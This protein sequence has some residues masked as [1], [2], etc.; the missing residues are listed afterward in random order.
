MHSNDQ[1]VTL[2]EL[3]AHRNWLRRACAA[4]D[5]LGERVVDPDLFYRPGPASEA[6][7]KEVCTGCLIRETCLAYALG[8]HGAQEDGVWGGLTAAE[9]RVRRRHERKRRARLA[10]YGGHRPEPVANWSPSP[11]QATLLKAL[12]EEPDLRA[13]ADTL[14]TPFA[15]VRWVFAQMCEQLG[16]YP[17]ELTESELVETAAERISGTDTQGPELGVAA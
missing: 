2:A 10:S 5:E 16:F 17:D 7:A 8:S 11:A 4:T 14:E 1:S 3:Q 12:A 6:D 15:N 9:R 13:A